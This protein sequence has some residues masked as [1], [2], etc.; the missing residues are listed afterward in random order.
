VT[1]R[2]E[3]CQ[4]TSFPD[5]AFD[6]AFVGLV[7]HFTTA[8]RTAAEMKRI[9]VPG[10]RLIVANVNP[11]ALG[12]FARLR[13]LVRM[14]YRGVTGY[15]TKPPKSFVVTMLTASEVGDV[16]SRSGFRVDSIETFKDM[17]RPSSI[18]IDYVCAVKA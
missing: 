16:L 14:F 11:K 17:S 12:G 18:P 2:I 15:Q 5:R 7:I 3:D 13:S 4:S 1:F 9:L 10:G 6:T 8:E